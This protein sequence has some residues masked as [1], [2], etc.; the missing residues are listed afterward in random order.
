[1]KKTLLIVLFLNFISLTYSQNKDQ[2]QVDLHKLFQQKVNEIKLKNS[3]NFKTK[4]EIL[5]NLPANSKVVKKTASVQNSPTNRSFKKVAKKNNSPITAY[6]GI[7]LK[8]FI[9]FEASLLAV[10]V[11]MYRRKRI[12]FKNAAK[13]ELKHNIN[14]LRKEKL[15]NRSGSELVNVRKSL[16]RKK[17]KIQKGS[18]SITRLAKKLSI[19]KGEVHLAIKLNMIT[20]E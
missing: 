1:M 4:K 13:K 10:I 6:K 19:A 15:V 8:A 18:L 9:L 16:T 3:R 12:G 11:V 20:G 2:N 7:L 5:Q 17:I 14:L